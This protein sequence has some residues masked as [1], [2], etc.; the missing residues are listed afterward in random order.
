MFETKKIDSFFSG[1]TNILD[2]QEKIFISR[3][4]KI[5]RFF[6]LFLPCLTALLLGLGFVL[7]DFETNFDNSLPLRAEEKVYFEKFK[8]KNTVLELT[9]KD[10][11]FSTLRADVIEEIEPNSKIYDLTLP[12]AQ[13]LENDNIISLTAQTGVFNQNT[14]I[15]DLKTDVTATYNKEM[16]VKTNSISYNFSTETG[17]GNEKIVG[18]GEKGHFE[19]E[20]FKFDKKNNTVHLFKNVYLKSDDME[21]RS[22]EQ[23][24][25]YKDE[26]KFVS[27]D[28]VMHKGKDIIQGD[29]LTAYFKN[30][31][32]FELSKAFS[33]GHT[34]ILSNGKKAYANRGV[35]DAATELVT[36]F[37]KV[38]IIDDSGYTATADE[39]TFDNNN[40][41]FTLNNN[42]VI[43]NK[44]GHK[45]FAQTGTYDLNN[46]TFTLKDGVRIEKGSNIIV[47]PKA[48]YFQA[49][50]EFRLY[51]NVKITQD[52]GE[53]TAKSGV[54]YIKKNLA[55][56]EHNVV[57]TKAGNQVRGEKAIADF[58][59]S[60]SRLVGKDGGR[61]FGK[62]FENTFHMKKG[63]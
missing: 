34:A 11:Q 61:V 46:K 20:S 47:S 54:Y 31:K 3:R 51:D 56:L 52:D 50:D 13:T 17:Y 43:E 12:Q 63:E 44:K 1:E 10:N 53:V 48:V 36:L 18:D 42:V 5:V 9:E 26:N 39:G 59:T 60:K 24:I 27:T 58:S 45:A 30:T 41:L 22:P 55:E 49:K 28:A 23:A 32:N 7:F 4:M 40:K 6:K 38:T 21:L 33:E 8:M 62:L 14:K 16:V 2:E 25:L 35:Y 19:A 37:G 29:T 57:I 15:L